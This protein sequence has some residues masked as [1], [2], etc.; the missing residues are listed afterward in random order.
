[1][2][3]KVKIIVIVVVLAIAGGVVAMQMMGGGDSKPK[4]NMT[5]DETEEWL[6]NN[7][8]FAGGEDGAADSDGSSGML[9][10]SS[11]QKRRPR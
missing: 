6:R 5:A 8:E 9:D 10:A 3:D 4:S 2:S 1:M 11:F 7:P